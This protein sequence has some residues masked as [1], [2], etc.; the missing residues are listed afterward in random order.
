MQT[1]PNEKNLSC[2]LFGGCVLEVVAFLESYVVGRVVVLG[3][4]HACGSPLH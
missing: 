2:Q 4:Y 3:R 1:H